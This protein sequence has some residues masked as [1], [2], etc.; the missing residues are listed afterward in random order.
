MFRYELIITKTLNE[1][2]LIKRLKNNKLEAFNKL[3][4]YLD[5]FSLKTDK[6]I[7]YKRFKIIF[8]ILRNMGRGVLNTKKSNIFIDIIKKCISSK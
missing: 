6:N 2:N 3:I 5:E 7:A 4:I 8:I 1:K